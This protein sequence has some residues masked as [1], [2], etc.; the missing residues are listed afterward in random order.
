M[1]KKRATPPKLD[2]RN[3]FM[4]VHHTRADF[5]PFQKDYFVVDLGPR[6]GIVAVRDGCV[7]LTRQY[8][9][10]ID[11][12][13]WEIPGGRVDEGET[14]EVAAVRECVEETGVKCSGLSPLVTYYPGLDN[15]DNR[16]TLFHSSEPEVVAPFVADEAEVVEI[17]W[18]DVDTCLDMIF[19]EEILDA[20]TVAG[21]L[22]YQ[23]RVRSGNT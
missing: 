21:L 6:A 19:R 5:G 7:L 13:S 20:L 22:A 16:T 18:M 8:R 9:Y 12:Y 15:F 14:P 4:E 11:D 1:R 10:L 23:A 17:R 2:Y 3:R